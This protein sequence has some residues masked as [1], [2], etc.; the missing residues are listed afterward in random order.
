M[1]GQSALLPVVDFS[2]ALLSSEQRTILLEL[3]MRDSLNFDSIVLV[4]VQYLCG[5]IHTRFLQEA[6]TVQTE[7]C[8][9]ISGKGRNAE[10]F[11]MS[12]TY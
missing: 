5:I 4:I 11:R 7:F 9:S 6:V 3:S 8:C 1:I 12:K 10:Y 2:S